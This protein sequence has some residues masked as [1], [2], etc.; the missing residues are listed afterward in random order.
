M[1]RPKNDYNR[2]VRVDATLGC[3]G[4]LRVPEV[5]GE[6]GVDGQHARVAQ[7]E[8]EL[9]ALAPRV[10]AVET[11]LVMA[12]G[13]RPTADTVRESMISLELDPKVHRYLTCINNRYFIRIYL[14]FSFSL[15]SGNLVE[16]YHSM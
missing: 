16:T 1:R 15:N 5:V 7:Q 11:S 4:G 14:A 12:Q 10:R 9:G 8:A 13:Q 6:D 3:L 2:N